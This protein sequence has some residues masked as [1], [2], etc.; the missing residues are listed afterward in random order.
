[1]ESYSFAPLL[2]NKAEKRATTETF[3]SFF[4]RITEHLILLQKTNYEIINVELVRKEKQDNNDFE[5]IRENI[6]RNEASRSATGK[7]FVFGVRVYIESRNKLD[8]PDWSAIKVK[9][10]PPDSNSQLCTR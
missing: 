6:P 8:A 1:M 10:R 5:L 3:Q 4:K 2:A 9:T 7:D